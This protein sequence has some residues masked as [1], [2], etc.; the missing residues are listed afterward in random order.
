[1]PNYI[2]YSDRKA[3]TQYRDVLQN[4]LRN[5]LCAGGTRQGVD[6]L[7]LMQQTMQ[8]DLTGGFPLITDRDISGFWN[9][10]IGELCAFINGA[11]T[12]AELEKFGCTWWGPWTDETRAKLFG[13]EVGEIGPASYG[14]AFHDFPTLDGGRFDQFEHLVRQI[15]RNPNDRVH[16]VTP[17]MP[18]EN[19]RA[20]DGLQKTTIA[21]CHGWVHVRIINS[22]L[23]LHMYQRAGDVP[24]GVPS[25]M[26]QYAAL[27]LMLEQLTGYRAAG[28]YH[29]ISDAHIFTDQVEHVEE[30]LQREP[31]PLPTVELTPEGKEIT[32]IHDFRREHFELKDYSPHPPIREI[33]VAT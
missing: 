4:I 25:N 17:W 8:F 5:G 21:P 31:K 27:A 2:P 28:Y 13:L 18:K 23:H 20:E 6:A 33:P 3:N 1:M 15:K 22:E 11:T 7:T 29:T 9:R 16:I 10:G 19:S 32:D 24:V 12:T 30:M 26:V 14:G